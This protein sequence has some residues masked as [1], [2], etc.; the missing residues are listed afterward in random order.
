[1]ETVINSLLWRNGATALGLRKVNLKEQTDEQDKMFLS[2]LDTFSDH[3][4]W[5]CSQRLMAVVQRG[6]RTVAR[7][8]KV[9]GSELLYK[10]RK[11][12]SFPWGK[13]QK[14]V[15]IKYQIIPVWCLNLYVQHIYLLEDSILLLGAK[16]KAKWACAFKSVIKTYWLKMP[17][18]TSS[19]AGKTTEISHWSSNYAYL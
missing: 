14:V 5:D 12:S 9:Q 13:I 8:Q 11:K 18:K 4:I 19:Q 2:R 1:M 10:D 3:N 7:L 17:L 15:C 6:N 16:G